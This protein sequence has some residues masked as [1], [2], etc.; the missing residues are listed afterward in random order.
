MSIFISYIS[1]NNPVVKINSIE[2]ARSCHTFAQE[3]C[4][5]KHKACK[6]AKRHGVD[7]SS[8][9]HNAHTCIVVF[10]Q[11][12]SSHAEHQHQ[13]RQAPHEDGRGS[14]EEK[15]NRDKK[16]KSTA[17]HR[18][19]RNVDSTK[20]THLHSADSRSSAMDDCGQDRYHCRNPS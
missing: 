8:F 20:S 16:Q 6:G 14:P 12:D 11:I 7:I 1:K 10:L 4:F 3:P 9:I 15:G 17:D 2:I 5:W 19:A 13:H 18:I